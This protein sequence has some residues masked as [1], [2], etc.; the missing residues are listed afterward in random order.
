MEDFKNALLFQSFDLTPDL[1][2]ETFASLISISCKE[3]ARILST[4]TKEL[5]SNSQGRLSISNSLES[6]PLESIQTE[7]D[8]ILD[9]PLD[10]TD[11]PSKIEYENLYE[12]LSTDEK[13]AIDQWYKWAPNRWVSAHDKKYG[14]KV[15]P[16]QRLKAWQVTLAGLIRDCIPIETLPEKF[17]LLVLLLSSHQEPLEDDKVAFQD[18]Q[19]ETMDEIQEESDQE[20]Q[21]SDSHY[22]KPQY[23]LRTRR[24]RVL[25][26]QEEEEEDPIQ[27]RKSSRKS[28]GN[29]TL[30]SSPPRNPT[31]PKPSKQVKKMLYEQ[32]C[33]NSERGFCKISLKHK[34]KILLFMIETYAL[35]FS[36]IKSHIEESL[37][38]MT[39]LKKEK[40]ELAREIRLKYILFLF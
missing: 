36:K 5:H 11:S 39:E 26:L 32:L 35:T 18:P 20:D 13:S 2:S 28:T 31:P 33:L 21:D 37:E 10:M 15:E 4:V 22:S 3:W 7:S 8:M 23:G 38:K 34:I 27:L 14:V 16:S 40:R 9:A 24:S 17:D 1:I 6:L 25:K 29:A 19:D 12:S 30:K